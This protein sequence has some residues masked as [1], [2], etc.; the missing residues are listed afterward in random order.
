MKNRLILAGA[1]S[2]FVAVANG[3]VSGSGT[4]GITADVQGS[5]NLT[6]VTDGSGM[7]V[8]GTTTAVASLPLGNVQMYGGSTPAGVTKATNSTT[9]FTLSTPFDIKV[10]LANTTSANYSLT[11]ALSTPDAVNKWLI[12]AVDISAGGAISITSTGA[13]GSVPYT[14]ALTVPASAAAGSISN[15]ISFVATSN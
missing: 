10:D 3:Q 8:T 5:I 6:F 1:F 4:M 11:A 12:S 13:Y 15:T 14:L 7:A 2:A 9:S